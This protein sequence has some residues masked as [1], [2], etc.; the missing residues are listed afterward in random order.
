MMIIKHAEKGLPQQLMDAIS[1]LAE[2][3]PKLHDDRQ[4]W[5]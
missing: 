3:E 5:P 4:R 2:E 1:K